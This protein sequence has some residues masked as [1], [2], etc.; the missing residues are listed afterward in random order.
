MALWVRRHSESLEV[1]EGRLLTQL[2]FGFFAPTLRLEPGLHNQMLQFFLLPPISSSLSLLPPL[3]PHPCLIPFPLR[4]PKPSSSLF[5]RRQLPCA[6]L[7]SLLLLPPFLSPSIYSLL[8]SP[9]PKPFQLCFSWSPPLPAALHLPSP[10]PANPRPYRTHVSFLY[11]S[12]GSASPFSTSW[13]TVTDLVFLVR[14]V[15]S[16]SN[17]AQ[18]LDH[19]QWRLLLH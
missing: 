17:R 14:D 2:S 5:I 15:H 7:G 10:L 3:L 18:E 4:K 12:P 16:K 11:Q 19:D 1:P 9:H 13:L 8:L 6:L